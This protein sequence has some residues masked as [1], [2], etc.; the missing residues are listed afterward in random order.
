MAKLIDK[1]K[2]Y[3]SPKPK[4]KAIDILHDAVIANYGTPNVQVIL[5][6]VSS[7]DRINRVGALIKLFDMYGYRYVEGRSVRDNCSDHRIILRYIPTFYAN[8]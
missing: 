5:Y 6:G 8:Y 4:L 1:I 7:K 2:K 3:L